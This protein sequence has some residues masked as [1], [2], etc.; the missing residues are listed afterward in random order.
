MLQKCRLLI[1]WSESSGL[2]LF[3]RTHH[4]HALQEVDMKIMP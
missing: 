3:F 1:V 4:V 2:N